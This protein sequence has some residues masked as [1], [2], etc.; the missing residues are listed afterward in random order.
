M[1][2]SKW[3]AVLRIPVRVFLPTLGALTLDNQHDRVLELV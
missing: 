1:L 2:F 3:T